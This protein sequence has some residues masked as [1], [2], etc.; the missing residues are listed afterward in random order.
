MYGHGD[1][2]DLGTVTF[3]Q[4]FNPPLTQGSAWSLKKFGPGISEKMFKGVNGWTDRRRTGSDHNSSSWAFSSDEL[5]KKKSD[6]KDNFLE[7]G[8]HE[9]R[10]LVVF[11]RVHHCPTM[12]S[13][14][15]GS[16]WHIFSL[17]LGATRFNIAHFDNL[18]SYFYQ[19]NTHVHLTNSSLLVLIM[20]N[21]AFIHL[22]LLHSGTYK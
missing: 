15:R 20:L 6:N 18:F 17:T 19:P 3:V 12:F 10:S 5:K 13:F 9:V 22:Y 7:V 4:I 11:S 1:H 2:L 14:I 21:T 8:C 16:D